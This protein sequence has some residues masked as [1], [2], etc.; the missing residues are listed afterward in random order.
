MSND[1]N[2]TDNEQPIES[3]I[4]NAET[5][6]STKTTDNNTVIDEALECE[7]TEEKVAESRL[8]DSLLVAQEQ[9]AQLKDQMVRDQ[10]ET[11]NIRKRLQGEVEKA[12][13]FALEKFVTELLP[14]A[15]NLERAM[16]SVKAGV[17]SDEN[18]AILEGIE[19]T[20]KSFL[21][22]LEKF[23]VKQ[24]DP[25]GEPFDASFHQAI[26]MV[27]NADMEPNSVM[28]CMQKGYTL[29]DRLVRPAMVIVSKEA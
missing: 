23:N 15:D 20:S 26:T 29:N 24:I 28:E 8:E 16:T 18:K 10:A 9:I 22:A 3:V 14:V 12:R 1:A 5:I 13:K 7:S 6:D 11:Q 17:E 2:T 4:E 21:Q 19:L 25:V 27:P